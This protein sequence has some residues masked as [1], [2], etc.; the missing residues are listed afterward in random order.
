VS[1]RAPTSPTEGVLRWARASVVGGVATGLSLLG[2]VSAGG[3]APPAGWLLV[4][5]LV[6]LLVSAGL[7]G[8]RW[9][10]GPLLGLLLGAQVAFHVA[11]G[12]RSTGH[13]PGGQHLGHAAMVPGHSGVAMLA[14]HALAAL[15]TALL[16]RRGED[17]AWRAVDLLA[18]VWTVVRATA[19][20]S[21]VVGRATTPATVRVPAGLGLLEHV[22]ARRGPPVLAAA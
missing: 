2:H 10:L 9:T 8:R 20:G 15:L 4:L 3:S 7:S 17:C 11:F 14:G 1:G 21:I 12:S 19:T 18:R 22:V 5:A 16:L 13:V 6:T